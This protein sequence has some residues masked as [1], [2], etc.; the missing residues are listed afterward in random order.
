MRR[1][2]F[3][4]LSLLSVLLPGVANAWWQQDWAYRKPIT[5][6]ATAQGAALGGDAGRVPVLVRLHTGNFN[7]QGVSE[8][9]ADPVSYTHLTLPTTERV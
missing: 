8:T 6:D 5:V 9:G 1:I 7:F 4:A 3:L 2:L